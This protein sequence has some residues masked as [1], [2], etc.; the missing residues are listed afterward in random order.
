MK[1]SVI[2]SN[3]EQLSCDKPIS[4]EYFALLTMNSALIFAI[5]IFLSSDNNI[6]FTTPAV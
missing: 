3:K 4:N 6:V 2:E 1:G 5:A